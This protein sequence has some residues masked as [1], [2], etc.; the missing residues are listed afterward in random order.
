MEF[1]VNYLLIF[2]IITRFTVCSKENRIKIP[3]LMPKLLKKK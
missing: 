2:K 1:E 3:I